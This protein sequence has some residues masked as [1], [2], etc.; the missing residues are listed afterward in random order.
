M[1]Q[2]LEKIVNKHKEQRS[3]VAII[4]CDTITLEVVEEEINSFVSNECELL[5]KS[6]NKMELNSDLISVTS[7]SYRGVTI[8]FLTNANTY[9]SPK[10]CGGEP[11]QAKSIAMEAEE[12][13]N[14]ERAKAYGDMKESFS[15]IAK[16]WSVIAKTE[17]TPE[18]VGLMMIALKICREIN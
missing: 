8:H 12:V 17:I 15:N 10:T 14:G 16:M 4:K 7:V 9:E 1:E 2:F 13:V 18:Q 6:T 3:K 11:K 5:N